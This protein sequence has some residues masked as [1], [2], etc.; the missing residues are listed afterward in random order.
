MNLYNKEKALNTS[1]FGMKLKAKLKPL[2]N[3]LSDE[4]L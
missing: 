3:S 4:K 2:F 1:E